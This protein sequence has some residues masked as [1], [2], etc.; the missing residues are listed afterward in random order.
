MSFSDKVVL[1]TGGSSGIGAVTAIEFTKEKANVA[2]VGRNE[3]KLNTVV[4][5]CKQHGKAPFVIKADVSNDEDANRI[6]N[7][8][9][10]KYGKLDVLVNNAGFTKFGSILDGTVVEA[11]DTIMDT[12]VR[13]VIKLTTLAAPHLI[14]TKGNIVNVSSI[15][16]F[17]VKVVRQNAYS[18]SKAAVNHFTKGAALELATS[19]VR[20]NAVSPGPVRTDILENAGSDITWD[21]FKNSVALNRISDPEEV[22]NVILY[23]SS[24][25]AKGVTGS[26]YLVDNG[27][28]LL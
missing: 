4:E 19:G 27:R 1:I 28:L 12:N 8:T 14:K 16:G 6:I 22:A 17:A 11:Y 24:D 21:S 3:A 25:K 10:N 18:L 7:E 13:A 15:A 5:K 20:V 23:L 9:V 26:N 2:I